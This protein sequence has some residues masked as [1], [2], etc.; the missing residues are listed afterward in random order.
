MA[1]HAFRGQSIQ[2][3]RTDFGVRSPQRIPVLLVAG[4][5]ENVWSITHVP[6]PARIRSVPQY[7]RRDATDGDQTDRQP[8]IDL[9]IDAALHPQ[10]QHQAHRDSWSAMQ[11]EIQ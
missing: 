7:D 9:F 11:R 10:T 6:L 3:G 4:D 1:T 2:M 8:T 5:E